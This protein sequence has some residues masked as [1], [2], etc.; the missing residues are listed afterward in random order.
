MCKNTNVSTHSENESKFAS[1][2]GCRLCTQ[3]PVAQKC[4]QPVVVPGQMAEP[5]RSAYWFSSALDGSRPASAAAQSAATDQT[6][7]LKYLVHPFLSVNTFDAGQLWVDTH[8]KDLICALAYIVFMLKRK[9]RLEQ[10]LK[11]E[12][13]IENK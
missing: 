10:N 1:A 12:N 13:R 4:L 7:C 3:R 2:I 11:I 5:M 6:S 9:R 8:D